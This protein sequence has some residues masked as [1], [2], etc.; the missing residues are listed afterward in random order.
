MLFQ[1]W[2]NIL[3]ERM[4]TT[5]KTLLVQR[6]NEKQTPDPDKYPSQILCLA[7]SIIF[8]TKCEQALTGMTL[9]TLLSKY[10]VSSR[11]QYPI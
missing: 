1:E 2:L 8:T 3:V 6:Q 5:L 11:F 4:Q 7:E 9:S 10:K